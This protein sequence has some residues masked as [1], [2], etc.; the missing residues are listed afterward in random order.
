MSHDANCFYCTKDARLD[1]L[2]IEVCPL[3]VTTLYLFRDQTHRGRCIVT[4]NDHKKEL[5]DLGGDERRAWVDD[6]ARAAKAIFEVVQPSKIN[7]GAF[8]DKNSHF[9]L[10]LVPKFEAGVA[11][12]SMFEMSPAEKKLASSEELRALAAQIR[13]RLK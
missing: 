4:L 2:M 10:H 13:L 5:F 7:Y 1:E 8:G 3:S 12:G 6:V 9:H 11:W